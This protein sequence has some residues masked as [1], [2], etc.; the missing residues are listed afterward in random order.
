M[1]RQI[2][3]YVMITAGMSIAVFAIYFFMLPF[4]IVIGSMTGLALVLVRLIPFSV[5]LMT[6]LL[7]VLCLVAG[8][9]LVGKEFGLKT[10]YASLLQP[11]F[12]R[13][14]EVVFPNQESLTG[15]VLLDAVAFVIVASVGQAVVFHAQASS[16]GLDIIAKII[17]RYLHI[18]LGKAVAAAGITVVLSSAFVYDTRTVVLGFLATYINGMVIDEYISGFRKKKKVCVISPEYRE[19]CQYIN[20]ELNRGATLYVAKGSYENVERTEVVSILNQNEY[21]RL[22]HKIQETDPQAFVTVSTVN[23]VSGAWNKKD[24][25]YRNTLI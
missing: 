9:L 18:E 6:L 23:E 21:A 10:V 20:K 17:N 11:L 2:K 3:E 15:E 7:N 13:I 5:S 19:L 1:K 4:N 24:K 25:R 14:C 8:F 16:G 12:L 22:M